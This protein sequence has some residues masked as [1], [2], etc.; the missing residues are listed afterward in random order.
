M[1]KLFGLQHRRLIAKAFKE[2]GITERYGTGIKRIL[3]ICKNYGVI[4][5]VFEEVFNGFKVTLFKKKLNEGVN[6]GLNDELNS[7]QKEVYLFIK[8]KSGIMAKLISN[9]LNM[10]FGTVDRHIRV[11]L[12]KGLI[13]RRGSKKTGGYYIIKK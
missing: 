7:G 11:L 9:E 10:P 12:K 4:P 3:D 1:L 13:E 5:P 8:N 2:T 6:D